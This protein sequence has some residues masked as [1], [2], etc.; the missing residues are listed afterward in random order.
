M[1]LVSG[2]GVWATTRYI[3][4]DLVHEP[5]AGTLRDRQQWRVYDW[6]SRVAQELIPRSFDLAWHYLFPDYDAYRKEAQGWL[7][8]MLH[9]LYRGEV[10]PVELTI[11]KTLAGGGYASGRTIGISTLSTYVIMHEFAHVN[12]E[13]EQSHDENFA[14]TWLML[15]DRYVPNF[16]TKR[17]RELAEQYS[18]EIGTAPEVRP[19]SSLTRAVRQLTAKEAPLLPSDDTPIASEDLHYSVVLE[20]GHTYDHDD[21]MYVAKGESGGFCVYRKSENGENEVR[22]HL[23]RV[24]FT[25]GP[26]ES[27]NGI[28]VPASMGHGAPQGRAVVVGTPKAVGR[29]RVEIMTKCPGV[30]DQEYRLLGH[31]EIIVVD[32][33][34]EEE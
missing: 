14:A 29:V 3:V 18:V 28:M 7:D 13:V 10:E 19:V 17:A 34:A 8:A 12:A 16:D 11:W 15:W 26:G 25:V 24:H 33:G 2:V 21:E 23:P 27:W 5:V 22:R 30:T 4:R 32:P 31:S 1:T 9:D 20:L 6:G